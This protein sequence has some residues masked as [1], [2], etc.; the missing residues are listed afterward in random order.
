MKIIQVATFWIF[1]NFLATFEHSSEQL[2]S[3]L[4]TKPGQTLGHHSAGKVCSG[5]IW[6]LQG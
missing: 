1:G 6:I 2:S 5:D 4:Q 3:F